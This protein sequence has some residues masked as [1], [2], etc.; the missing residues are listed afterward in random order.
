MAQDSPLRIIFLADVSAARVI[1]G[2]ER[3]LAEEARGLAHRGHRVTVV[4]RAAGP[5]LTAE[6]ELAPGLREIR[7]PFD[8]GRPHRLLTATWPTVRRTFSRL[9]RDGGVDGLNIHQPIA[10]LGAAVS[11]LPP[12]VYT[13]HSLSHEEYR[14]RNH[15]P[16]LQRWVQAGIR[17]LIERRVMRSCRR[18]V[19]L[20]RY[21]AEKAVR[22]HRIPPDRIEVIPGG[23]DFERFR[24][25]LDREGLRRR[26][27]LEPGRRLLLTVRN[28][29]PRMGLEKLIAAMADVAPRVPEAVLWVGGEGPLR[30]TLEAQTQALGLKRRVRFLGF[31]PE[32][33]LPDLYAAADLFVLPSL[34]LEGFGMVTLEALAS[35]LPVL[36]TPVGGSVEIL[37]PLDR[38]LLLENTSV[39]AIG[40]GIL[41][42]LHRLAADPQAG[43]RLSAACRRH[44]VRGYS[45]ER[46]LDRL[47][48]LFQTVASPLLQATRT[49]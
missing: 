29:E 14:S 4:C 7:C 47:E 17:R 2:A 41:S 30:E 40:R 44:V 45:W 38:E 42:F 37:S 36:A 8:P 46:H 9:Q 39:K 32:E 3:V 23:V 5:G 24:P 43:R 27:G 13:C 16:A 20:S 15:G 11:A 22:V 6:E 21:T 31:V 35:G 33:T 1:G 26:L 10:A 34:D 18:V 12:A 28:L 25:A 48:A 19:T 49:G